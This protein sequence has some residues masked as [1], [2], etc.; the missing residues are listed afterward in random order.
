MCIRVIKSGATTFSSSIVNEQ[1]GGRR[2][3]FLTD[4]NTPISTTVCF[5]QAVGANGYTEAYLPIVERRKSDG[6]GSSGSVLNF[7]AAV[8]TWSSIWYG[9]RGT[10]FGLQTGGRIDL[11]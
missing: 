1:R 10:L 7:I 9:D 8:A 3:C 4:L 2:A 5:M 6:L 11:S